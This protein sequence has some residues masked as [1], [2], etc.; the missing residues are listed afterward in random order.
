M[1]RTI[2][3]IVLVVT[4]I[5]TM[6]GSAFANDTSYEN[7]AFT[8]MQLVKGINDAGYDIEIESQSDS[9]IEYCMDVFVNG[10]NISSEN[11]VEQLDDGTIRLECKEA[12]NTDIVFLAELFIL[13]PFINL[14]FY[15]ILFVFLNFIW[16]NAFFLPNIQ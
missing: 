16:K 15:Q 3:S 9:K 14:N 12:D 11:V 1:K 13:S 8:V 10:A 2:I 6:T 5:V 4:M 7:Q